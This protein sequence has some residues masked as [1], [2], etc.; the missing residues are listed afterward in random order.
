MAQIDTLQYYEHLIKGGD[1]P[2]EA[3]AHIY[4]LNNAVGDLPT[5]DDLTNLETRIDAK[6]DTKFGIL[7][8]QMKGIKTIGWAIFV[9]VVLPNLASWLPLLRGYK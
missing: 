1:T 4:A 2:L 3:K 8:A 9:G 6:L 7:G 5:K